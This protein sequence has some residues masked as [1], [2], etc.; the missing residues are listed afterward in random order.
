MISERR[1]RVQ[2]TAVGKC[3]VPLVVLLWWSF[4]PL[5]LLGAEDQPGT[6]PVA[7]WARAV[8]ETNCAVCHGIYGDGNGPAA[9]MFL[10]R[11]R[12]FRQ[13]IFK[14]RSTPSGSLPADGDLRQTVT[15]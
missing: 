5:S 1:G 6:R 8:Y 11:P 10:A 13:G 2:V 7:P 9:H 4:P 15:Q 3:F 12:D 14:F